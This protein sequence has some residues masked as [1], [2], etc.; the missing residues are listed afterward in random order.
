[1]IITARRPAPAPWAHIR[2]AFYLGTLAGGFFA[3]LI[4][5]EH[6]PP[7]NE[8]DETSSLFG[9]AIKKLP[10]WYLEG[11]PK[12]PGGRITFTTWKHFD[13]DSPLLESGLSAP[14]GC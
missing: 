7:E 6:L 1:M 12:P 8:Y 4:G 3:G 10:A 2:R 9:G 11:K 14:F 5:D 13:K